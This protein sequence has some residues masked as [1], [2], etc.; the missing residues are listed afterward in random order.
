M[1]LDEGVVAGSVAVARRPGAE[2][3][4][5]AAVHGFASLHVRGPLAETPVEE[6]LAAL[7]VMLD[8][9]SRGML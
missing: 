3:V 6:R 5:W 4:C 9:V 8:H 2:V 1:V 7:E